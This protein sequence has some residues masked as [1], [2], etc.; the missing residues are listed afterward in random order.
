MKSAVE[1]P[2]A[3]RISLRRPRGPCRFIVTSLAM[4]ARN[5]RH[6]YNNNRLL[7]VIEKPVLEPKVSG[8]KYCGIQLSI[9]AFSFCFS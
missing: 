7:K 4:D 9:Q 5:H 2:A 3:S 8:K 1:G 6:V